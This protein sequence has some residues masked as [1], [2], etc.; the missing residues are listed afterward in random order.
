MTATAATCGIPTYDNWGPRVGAAYQ[1]NDKTVLRG[2]FGI[3]YLPTNTGYFSGPTDYGSANFSGGVHQPAYGTQPRRRAR[4]PVL[5]SR[6]DLARPRRGRDATRAS[7]ASARRGSTASSRTARRGSGTS[8]SSASFANRWMA[9]IGYSASVSRNLHNRSF[10]IQNLQSI[11]PAMLAHWRNQYIAS[12]GTLNPATQLVQNPCAAGDRPAGAVRRRPRRSAR[13]RGRTRSSRILCSSARMRPSTVA[14]QGGLPRDDSACESPLRRRLHARRELHL[15]EEH[16]TTATRLRTTRAS[17]PAAARAA[18]ATTS[19]TSSTNMPPRLQR[20]AAP[21]DRDVPLRTALRQG[22]AHR[23]ART[24]WSTRIAGGW[25]FGGVA[26]LADRIPDRHLRRER[27][28]GAGA[29]GPRRRAS[30]SCCRRTCGAG[31]TARRRVTLP[32]GRVITPPNRTYLKY[33]PD[34]FVGRVVTTPNGRHRRGSVLVRQRRHHLRRD[35]DRQPLQ[36]R[37]EHPAQRS[38]LPQAM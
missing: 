11:D 33:N 3:T 21:A 34:A 8:S 37:P 26:H 6:A 35:P 15:V 25:Q 18:S 27:R 24:R 32:S 17:T 30:R 16:A 5:G 28:R 20:H 22:K 38:A 13:S 7:T 10:P 19:R 31:T 23:R 14:G 1:W 9:S 4:D 12:N 29:S 36:H 2:G